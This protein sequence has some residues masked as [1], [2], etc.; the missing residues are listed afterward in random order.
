LQW[1]GFVLNAKGKG[2][3]VTLKMNSNLKLRFRFSISS[4][5]EMGL[6]KLGFGLHQQF[7]IQN[8]IFL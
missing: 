8:T 4:L 3:S 5:G 1:L 2:Q 7:E 6:G